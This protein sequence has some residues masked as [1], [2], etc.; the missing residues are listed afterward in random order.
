M[1]SPGNG[2]GAL[3]APDPE[4]TKTRKGTYHTGA[5]V[6]TRQGKDGGAM[7]RHYKLAGASA[8]HVCRESPS[9]VQYMG[10][11]H[12]HYAKC[13]YALCG[14]FIRWLPRRE[15]VERRKLSVAMLRKLLATESLTKWE[16]GFVESLSASLSR[17]KK[18]SPRQEEVLGQLYRRYFG[19]PAT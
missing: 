2:N 6:A 16:Q 15:S 13:V 10:S 19:G 3:Y 17:R 7:T 4:S 18:F 5:D 8:H 12:Q 14:R 9:F 1:E 11:E